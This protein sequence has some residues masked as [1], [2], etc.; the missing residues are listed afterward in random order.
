MLYCRNMLSN[1]FS[2]LV[3]MLWPKLVKRQENVRDDDYSNYNHHGP[4]HGYTSIP[5][6]GRTGPKPGGY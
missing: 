4:G 2:P 3:K 1:I 5:L 6:I